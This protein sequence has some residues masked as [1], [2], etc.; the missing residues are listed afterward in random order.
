M[1]TYRKKPVVI[2]AE[3]FF[4]DVK[5]WPVGVEQALPRSEHTYFHLYNQATGR[6][7]GVHPGDWIVTLAN[8][9][10]EVW[11]PDAFAAAYV[12]IKEA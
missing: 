5:P 9:H 4:P 6:Y 1:A 11:T 2:E 7:G 8:G 3:Q 10:R 12:L